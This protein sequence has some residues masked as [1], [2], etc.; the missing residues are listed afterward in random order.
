MI[1]DLLKEAFEHAKLPNSFNDMKKLGF[2]YEIIHVCPNDCMFYWD[3][4]ASRHT[5]KVCESSR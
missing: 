3:D 2:N 4:D 5:C 1:I